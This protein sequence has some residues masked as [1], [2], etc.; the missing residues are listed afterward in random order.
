MF[1]E[2]TQGSRNESHRRLYRAISI[3]G[4]KTRWVHFLRRFDRGFEPR[5]C[6][7]LMDPALQALTGMMSSNKVRTVFRTV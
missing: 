5:R 1:G 7:A 3:L 2:V 4:G 6:G